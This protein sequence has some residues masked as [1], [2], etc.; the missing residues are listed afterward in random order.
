MQRPIK[1]AKGRNIPNRHS[2]K[3]KL[4]IRG[5][6]ICW[7]DRNKDA[8]T[9]ASQPFLSD[10]SIRGIMYE[11]YVG[12]STNPCVIAQK[13]PTISTQTGTGLKKREV[14]TSSEPSNNLDRNKFGRYVSG[15]AIAR[16]PRV[17][18]RSFHQS[19]LINFSPSKYPDFSDRRSLNKI[20][21]TT[22]FVRKPLIIQNL[23]DW[24]H[25]S[26]LLLNK[27]NKAI[28]AWNTAKRASL[29]NSIIKG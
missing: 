1:K 11:K 25:G 7:S 24:F 28:R 21:K 13:T 18:R 26:E 20:R 3:S 8:S 6:A 12:S 9:H 22:I 16:K 19:S 14:A 2:I 4:K 10:F 27:K 29:E 17:I 15:A 23:S 5:I